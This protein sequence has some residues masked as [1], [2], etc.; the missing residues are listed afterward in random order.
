[1]AEDIWKSYMCTAGMI[2]ETNIVSSTL[3]KPNKESKLIK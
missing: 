2:V 3:N 1:M